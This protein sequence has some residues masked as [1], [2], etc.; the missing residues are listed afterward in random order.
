MSGGLI[1]AIVIV[2][3][4]VAAAVSLLLM[5]NEVVVS[6]DMNWALGSSCP[7]AVVVG[8]AGSGQSEDALGVG[9]QVASAVT[10]FTDR[11]TDQATSSVEVG[12]LALD[13]PAL[14]VIEGGLMAFMGDENMFDSVDEGRTELDGLIAGI[15]DSCDGTK[16]YII[17][18]SQGAS[19]IRLTIDELS[20]SYRT[21]V[22]GVGV[23]AD[24]YRDADDP[25]VE[26][27]TAEADEDLFG[28]GAPHTRD[29][30]FAGL[31]A[32]DWIDGSF[33]S[34]CARRD[35]VCN[36]SLVDLLVTD[37]THTDETYHGLGPELGELLA[38]DLLA[39]L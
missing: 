17:G 12:F 22:G 23:I 9:P 5:R 7:D 24:P 10:A 13:Y 2:V 36:F 37:V 21:A 14:G 3:V 20:E 34:A 25:L 32:P 29:G 30:I 1:A 31:S 33:Y 39:R 28:S 4:V 8:V 26:H 18:F 11:V 6:V 19:V 16:T 38:D 35:A 15:R 27:L